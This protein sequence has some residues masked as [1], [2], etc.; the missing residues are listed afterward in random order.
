MQTLVERAV[1]LG[2]GAQVDAA[3]PALSELLSQY[4]GILA[5]QVQTLFTSYYQGH[6]PLESL[7]I[8]DRLSLYQAGAPVPMDN[9]MP[10]DKLCIAIAALPFA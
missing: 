8:Y 7:S 2:L 9:T 5:S 3:S 6:R 4:A 1:V 10:K